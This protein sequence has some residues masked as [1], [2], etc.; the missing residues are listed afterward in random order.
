MKND[1]I[2]AFWCAPVLLAFIGLCASPS[3]AQSGAEIFKG[4][5][6]VCHG[7]DAKG[8]GPMGKSLQ[9]PD[10]TSA[11]VQKQSDTELTEAITKGK[12]K[13]PPYGDKLSNEQ[14]WQLVDRKS[15]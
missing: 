5:C 15:L 4:K 13:M 6:A 3:H 12:N 7:P 8:Q 10:L 14:I 1:V 9:V 2:R 11:D